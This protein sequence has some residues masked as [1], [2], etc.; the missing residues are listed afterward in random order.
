LRL[1]SLIETPAVFAGFSYAALCVVC[2]GVMGR[3]E[4]EEKA[5]AAVYIPLFVL[6]ACLGL[7]IYRCNML[8]YARM[9]LEL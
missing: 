9:P 1:V 2:A 5:G 6:I 7:C 3:I 4:R 8:T